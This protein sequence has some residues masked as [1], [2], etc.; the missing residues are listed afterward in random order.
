MEVDDRVGYHVRGEWLLHNK[1]EISAGYYD[2]RA[3]PY[4]VIDGQYAWRTRFYHLGARWRFNKGLTAIAQYL[5]G[6][7]LMQ[8]HLR[9]DVVK[10]DYASAFVSL[11]YQWQRLLGNKKHK[12]TIRIEDFSVTDN[13][14]TWGDNNNEDGQA[15]T[16]N[17]SYR[18]SK[19]WFLSTE[20]NIINSDRS[21]RYYKHAAIEL[22]EKQWQL[23]AR[24][25]F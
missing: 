23:S 8:S 14:N 12:T 1:G 16:L 19:Q 13:D 18:L 4:I 17:H 11:T 21:A 10:N 9:E 5:S 15:L 6:D 2:N 25:F 3:T 20:F 24:Y 7:T 22:V